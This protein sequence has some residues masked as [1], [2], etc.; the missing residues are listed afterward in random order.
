MISLQV[1]KIGLNP[2]KWKQTKRHPVS[3]LAIPETSSPNWQRLESSNSF[4][5]NGQNRIVPIKN[6]G[7][8]S[9][10]TRLDILKARNYN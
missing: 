6:K 2:K 8:D 5:N 1:Q 10:F 4:K 7:N 3:L 9:I